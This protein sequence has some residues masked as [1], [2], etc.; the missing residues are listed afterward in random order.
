MLSDALVLSHYSHG[1]APQTHFSS[2]SERG[3]VVEVQGAGAAQGARVRGHADL[4]EE[5]NGEEGGV[6]DVR[7]GAVGKGG[8]RAQLGGSGD[9]GPAGSPLPPDLE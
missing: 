5:G 6:G 8:T 3:A 1:A 4:G 7:V 9:P 2:W